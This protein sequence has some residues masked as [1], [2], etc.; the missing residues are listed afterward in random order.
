MKSKR[1]TLSSRKV[2]L[3]GRRREHLQASLAS[4]RFP[5]SSGRGLEGRELTSRLEGSWTVPTSKK[6]QQAG[7]G[8]NS[9]VKPTN[10]PSLFLNVLWRVGAFLGVQLVIGGS[11][12]LSKGRWFRQMFVFARHCKQGKGR[13]W[14]SERASP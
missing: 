10:E 1:L 8:K 3:L 7:N 4:E 11:G 14:G 13:E 9:P 2:C 6:V 5:G 12:K